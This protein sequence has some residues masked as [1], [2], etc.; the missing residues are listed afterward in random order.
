[1]PCAVDV[2]EIVLAPRELFERWSSQGQDDGR[3]GQPGECM[4]LC[5]YISHLGALDDRRWPFSVLPYL[6]AP[7]A[8][9]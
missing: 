4:G 5:L 7:E 2:T 3:D 8:S 1:V 6:E 9:A